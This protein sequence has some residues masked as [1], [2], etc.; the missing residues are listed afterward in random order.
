MAKWTPSH[1]APEPLEGPVVATITGGTILWFVLFLVQVPFYGWFADRDLD[2]WVWT[3]LAG[4]GLGLIGIWYVRRRDAALRRAASG[5][6]GPGTPG[7]PGGGGGSGGG[8]AGPG[9]PA[10]T[11][12]AAPAGPAAP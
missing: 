10:G 2:W 11:A 8:P 9:A 12:P 1:E 5:P 3:C 4:A 7:A 6:G